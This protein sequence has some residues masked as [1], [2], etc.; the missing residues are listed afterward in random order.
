MLSMSIVA[1]QENRFLLLPMHKAQLKGVDWFS[2]LLP[3]D[4]QGDSVY[5][6]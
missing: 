6:P 4:K 2:V 5:I 3:A 1:Q